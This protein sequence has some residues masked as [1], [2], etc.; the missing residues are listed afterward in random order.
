MLFLRAQ[1]L[2]EVISSLVYIYFMI[3]QVFSP[4]NLIDCRLC[5][6]TAAQETLGAL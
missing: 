6:F 4:P 3:P 2:L 1:K 5:L